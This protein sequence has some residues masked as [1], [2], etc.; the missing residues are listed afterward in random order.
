MRSRLWIAAILLTSTVAVFAQDDI[1]VETLA[2]P[3][4][5]ELAKCLSDTLA[6][7]EKYRLGPWSTVAD[8]LYAA[9]AAEI[10]QVES[11]AKD[12]LKDKLMKR[13]VPTQM[14]GGM[15]DNAAEIYMKKRVTSC[16]GTGCSLDEYRA[17]LM[18][19][20]PSAIKAKTRPIDFEKIG[21]QQCENFESAARSALTNDLDNVLKLHFAGGI[22]HKVND[23]ILN[24]IAGVRQNVVVL[25]GQDFVKIQPGRKP[26]E[27]PGISFSPDE[28][29]PTEYECVINQK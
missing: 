23:V 25:Y 9:C 8:V 29:E 16:S 13:I 21:Q 20:M 24:I 4:R 15:V 27:P 3:E 22:N 1:D 10:E 28:H 2:R 18:R 14:G 19:P 17:C 6:V 5:H 11:A 12:Q 7:I 26:C